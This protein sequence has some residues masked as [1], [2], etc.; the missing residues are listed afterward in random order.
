MFRVQNNQTKVIQNKNY[1]HSKPMPVNA[2]A[3]YHPPV[4]SASVHPPSRPVSAHPQMVVHPPPQ[5]QPQPQPVNYVIQKDAYIS[6]KE[7][8]PVIHPL[9]KKNIKIVEN[10]SQF[11]RNDQNVNTSG[12]IQPSESIK[13]PV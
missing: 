13:A 9:G 8:K 3:V 1:L 6:R 4:R 12:I 10:V 2:P 7:E 11:I 5:P